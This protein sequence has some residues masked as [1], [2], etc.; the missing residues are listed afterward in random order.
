MCSR[1]LCEDEGLRV[2]AVQAQDEADGLEE[3]LD[4]GAELLLLHTTGG[5]RVEDPGLDDELEQVLQGLN[6]DVCME[7][8]Q[9]EE[10]LIQC[11]ELFKHTQV[12]SRATQ[13]ASNSN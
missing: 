5:P 12:V 1:Y 3:L 10:T 2:A 4:A 6:S 7:W 11:K 9:E 13:K 8:T